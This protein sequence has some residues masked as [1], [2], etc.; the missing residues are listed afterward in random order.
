M[1]VDDDDDDS[2]MA[3]EEEEYDSVVLLTANKEKRDKVEAVEDLDGLA[4]QFD[5]TIITEQELEEIEQERTE[6]IEQEKLNKQGLTDY[7]KGWIPEEEE[8]GGDEEEVVLHCDSDGEM[9]LDGIEDEE[10]KQREIEK[11]EFEFPDEVDIP[12][13]VR[14]KDEFAQF[15]GL[16]YIA[17][18]IIQSDCCHTC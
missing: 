6:R 15:R 5:Q 4:S 8:Q 1:A 9:D 12:D 16:R 13:G 14:A 3:E 17:L 2:K 18:S 11:E 7:N 10:A